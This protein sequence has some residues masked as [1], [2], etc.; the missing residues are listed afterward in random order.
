ME[1]PGLFAAIM[2]EM[3]AAHPGLHRGCLEDHLQAGPDQQWLAADDVE[4]PEAAACCSGRTV[5]SG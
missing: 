4:K 1:K 2:A 3:M 5:A